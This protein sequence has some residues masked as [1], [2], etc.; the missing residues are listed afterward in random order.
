MTISLRYR[1]P[2]SLEYPLSTLLSE[3]MEE[4]ELSLAKAIIQHDEGVDLMPSITGSFL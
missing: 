2:D 3:V 4:K 1:E